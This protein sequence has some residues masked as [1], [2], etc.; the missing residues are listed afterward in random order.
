MKTSTFRTLAAG[1]LFA[2]MT[3]L[4]TAKE[5]PIGKP[6]NGGGLEIAAVYLQPIEMDPPGMMRPAADSDVHLEADIKALK[7]NKNGFAEGDWVPYLTV[8]F[9]LVKLDDGKKIAGDFMPMVASDG[10]HYGDNVKMNGPGKYKL[11][12]TIL[13]PGAT[14]GSHFGRHIDKETGV[15]KWFDPITVSWE[16]TYA[17]IG[18]KGAY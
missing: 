15:A 6:Q 18:K 17:G 1:M 10:P 4:A 9:E 2:G 13:P 16:F 8:K 7:T 12:Y 11:T 5:V 3:G 14:H